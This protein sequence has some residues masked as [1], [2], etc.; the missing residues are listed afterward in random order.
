M[1][2][3]QIFIDTMLLAAVLLGLSGIAKLF[4]GYSWSNRPSRIFIKNNEG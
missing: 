3:D 1:L 4:L 2:F